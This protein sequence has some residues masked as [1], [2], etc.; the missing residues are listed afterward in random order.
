M[1]FIIEIKL[2]KAQSK[3]IAHRWW[4]DGVRTTVA[5]W[6]EL[7]AG[8][9]T[10]PV[11]QNM[12]TSPSADCQ[13]DWD[14]ACEAHG[15]R[16]RLVQKTGSL[17]ARTQASHCCKNHCLHVRVLVALRWWEHDEKTWHMK[18]WDLARLNEWRS[19]ES[20]LN[21]QHLRVYKL[22]HSAGLDA[23]VWCYQEHIFQQ[24]HSERIFTVMKGFCLD[25]KAKGPWEC[26]V[27]VN[28]DI[29]VPLELRQFRSIGWNRTSKNI[30]AI[31]WGESQHKRRLLDPVSL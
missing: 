26:L 3:A 30:I 18:G 19:H 29:S 31:L 22:S 24:W 16:D 7:N 25:T 1:C 14:Q 20:A 23:D 10:H 12:G 21:P 8:W 13:E 11:H 5:V 15:K 28:G 2:T 6:A 27:A 4:S 9:W 17:W